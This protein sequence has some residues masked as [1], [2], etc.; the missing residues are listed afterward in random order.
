[1]TGKLRKI[2]V[3][4]EGVGCQIQQPRGDDTSPTPN[5]GDVSQMEGVVIVLGVAQWRSFRIGCAVCL[6]ADVSLTQNRQTLGVCR[7]NSVFHSVVDHLDEMTGATWAAV[8]VALF[9]GTPDL[10]PADGARNIAYSRS[11]GGE[12]WIEPLDDLGLTPNH[13]AVT[14]LQ[15]PNSSAGSDIDVV[16]LLGSELPCTPEIIDVIRIPTVNED[17]SRLEMR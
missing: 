9:G 15:T 4:N 10:V 7:H 17:V 11:E 3:L 16:D 13:H 14:S 8:Q 6:F 2:W 12:N 1:M 5:L